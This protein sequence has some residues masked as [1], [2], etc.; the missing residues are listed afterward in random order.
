MSK[1]KFV[2][3]ITVTDPDTG[4]EVN[5]SVY[6]HQGGGMLA[7]DSSYLDQCVDEDDP[8]IPDPFAQKFV[9]LMLEGD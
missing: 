1:A 3:T 5:L 6:K 9:K 8:I 2:T 4:N 7:M